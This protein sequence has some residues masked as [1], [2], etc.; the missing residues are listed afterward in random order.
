MTEATLQPQSVS[1]E[2]GAPPKYWAFISYS[3]KDEAWATWLH[4]SLEAYRIPRPLVRRTPS[5]ETPRRLIP[6]FRDRDELA[7]SADLGGTIRAALAAT[8]WLIVICSPSSAKSRWVNEEIKTFKALGRDHRVLCMIVNVDPK[9]DP[10]FPPAIF[11]RGGAPDAGP[12][13]EPLAVDLRKGKD[14][15]IDAKLKLIAA[16]IGVGFDVLKRREARR[17]R[18]WKLTAAALGVL[19]IALFGA[20]YVL[21]SDAGVNLP[22]AE[23]TR[24]LLD[25]HEFSV[26]RPVPSDAEI[27]R[28]AARLR[29]P[30]TQRLLKE[31]RMRSWFLQFPSRPDGVHEGSDVWTSAQ[32]LTGVLRSPDTSAEDLRDSLTALDEAFAPGYP[33]EV[34][35]R[36]YG[37]NGWTV[38]PQSGTQAEPA[39]WM[40][41]A[42]AIG[43][44]RP[45]LI[46]G[47]QRQHFLSRLGYTHETA[48][49]YIGG[50]GGW[51]MVGGTQPPTEASTYSTSL[52]L[53]ALLETRSAGLPWDGSEERRDVLLRTTAQWLIRRF[54]PSCTTPGWHGAQH[55][56]G[57]KSNDGLTLQIY[58]ELLRAHDEAGLEIPS[59]IQEAMSR[60]LLALDSRPF[61][62]PL[63][64]LQQNYAYSDYAGRPKDEMFPMRCLW[65]PWG[66]ECANRWLASSFAKDAPPEVRV[67]IRRVLGHM[68][69]QQAREIEAIA[70]LDRATIQSRDNRDTFV[71]SETLYALGSVPRPR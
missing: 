35:E 11:Q 9:A 47:D 38:G 14:A 61:Y 41:A 70:S 36:K 19:S 16:I 69:V 28:T 12:Q 44:G 13:P 27:R 64:T 54:E 20:G 37:W 24:T 15:R 31:W 48:R 46:Q 55:E 53:L 40:A 67:R 22:G 7:G 23:R 52:A 18:R 51:N 21:L 34:G 42:L 25:R 66:I 5:G 2:I 3:H 57:G 43:L 26:I 62:Y 29:A 58:G 59:Q 30:L 17:V 4:K 65:H 71:A 32:A 49:Q 60:H 56:V 10:E 1:P 33:I 68:V 45:G 39:L 63:D 8:R 6:I 50:D